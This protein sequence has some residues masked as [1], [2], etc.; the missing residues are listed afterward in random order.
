MAD[1]TI[2]NFTTVDMRKSN[3]RTMRIKNKCFHTFCKHFENENI[4]VTYRQMFITQ[5]VEIYYFLICKY[6]RNE[7]RLVNYHSVVFFDRE[8]SLD[9]L[10]P[11]NIYL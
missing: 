9:K 1:G 10:T 7:H 8:I 3:K 2:G 4:R 6:H 11:Q 5:F